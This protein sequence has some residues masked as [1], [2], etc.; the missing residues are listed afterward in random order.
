MAKPI[1]SPTSSPPQTPGGPWAGW[2]AVVLAL[3]AGMVAFLFFR[4]GKPAEG[5]AATLFGPPSTIE[6]PPAIPHPAVEESTPS[7]TPAA[8]PSRALALPDRF[9]E[10]VGAFRLESAKKEEAVPGIESYHTGRYE[11]P[12]GELASVRL[13]GVPE[14]VGA[15]FVQLA[16]RHLAESGSTPRGKAGAGGGLFERGGA[17]ILVALRGRMLV[18]VSASSPDAA[19]AFA[20]DLLPPVPSRPK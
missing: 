19:E 1:K 15:R 14:N 10:T 3:L 18:F 11:D 9:P 16:V 7:P 20:N 2:L 13:I 5:E 8:A 12:H 4:A 6:P 17:G